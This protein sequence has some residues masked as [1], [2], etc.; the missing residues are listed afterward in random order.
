MTNTIIK[1]L[2]LTILLI[3]LNTVISAND[4]RALKYIKQY[5]KEQ[6]VA[7]VIGN[8]AYKGEFLKLKNSKNDAY[9]MKQT[10]KKLG[11]DVFYLTD[12]NLQEMDNKVRQFIKELSKGGV[13][14]FYYAGHGIEVDGNNYLIPIDAD[15]YVKPEVKYNTLAVNEI[16]GKM[17]DSNNRLNIVVLDACRN[18]PF[19]RGGGGLA[20]INSA[21]GMYIS[22]ATAPGD[23][24]SDGSGRNGL[25]TK[26]LI[27]NIAIPNQTLNEV[28]KQT[29]M[30]V[31]ED[32]RDKQLPWSNSSVIGDFYFKL[33]KNQT[34]NQNSS[35]NF[36]NDTKNK[37]SLKIDAT[38]YNAKV[39]IT[40]IKPRYY[41]G[42]Q[43]K[44][45]HYK[46]K[47]SKDGYVTKRGEIDL[48]GDLVVNIVLEQKKNSQLSIDTTQEEKNNGSV[49]NNSIENNDETG[50][51]LIIIYI[52]AFIIL[53]FLSY[54][55]IFEIILSDE[56]SMSG[57]MWKYMLFNGLLIL[58]I[59]VGTILYGIYL[60]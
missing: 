50:L 3:I 55:Y 22:Y 59:Y 32:S 40:N 27:K 53:S 9:D 35:Y 15:I 13:G 42:I 25:F 28:F 60:K 2:K 43:L 45:G 47:V 57:D 11:F 12:G 48:K 44:K 58:N 17:E 14:M 5:S 6:K 39:Q 20:Q 51:F 46:I 54:V 56:H 37:Y 38:P 19:S 33:E 1:F 7:L 10:L 34:Q 26:H 23:V 16:V 52:I 4:T 30:G 41:D 49:Q 29:R 24:A 31:Y 8:G 36:N 18:D 21:K